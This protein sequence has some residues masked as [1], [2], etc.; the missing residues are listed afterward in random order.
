MAICPNCKEKYKIEAI[1]S[2]EFM[3]HHD[4]PMCP[5]GLEAYH[6]SRYLVKKLVN[7]HILEKFE[8]LEKAQFQP[9]KSKYLY[10]H[11]GKYL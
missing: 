6:T 10:K 8:W 3:A 4:N 11:N 2:F 5:F 7:E 1:N 9:L